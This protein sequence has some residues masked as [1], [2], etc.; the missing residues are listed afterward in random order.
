MLD[1]REQEKGCLMVVTDPSDL[2][3]GKQKYTYLVFLSLCIFRSINQW[4]FSYYSPLTHDCSELIGVDK[5]LGGN[6]LCPCLHS[7][8]QEKQEK[9]QGHGQEKGQGQGGSSLHPGCCMSFLPHDMPAGWA[10]RQRGQVWNSWPIC[11]VKILYFVLKLWASKMDGCK[12]LYLANWW[13]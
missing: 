5:W 4:A 10:G 2:G 1:S 13:S 3:H 8:G 9:G 12:V 6:L 11:N 7:W